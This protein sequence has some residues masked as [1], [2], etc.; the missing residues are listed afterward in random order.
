MVSIQNKLEFYAKLAWPSDIMKWEARF[1]YYKF[2]GNLD[3]LEQL[4]QDVV[5]SLE[6]TDEETKEFDILEKL[7]EEVMNAIVAIEDKE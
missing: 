1:D 3:L 7:C 2:L 4:H 5:H 6:R